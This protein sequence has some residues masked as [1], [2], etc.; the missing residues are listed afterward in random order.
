MHTY[1]RF[2]I[3]AGLSGLWYGAIELAGHLGWYSLI[4]VLLALP[5]V[6]CF[7]LWMR[8]EDERTLRKNVE[9]RLDT[10][11]EPAGCVPKICRTC[12][13]YD[14]CDVQDDDRTDFS[15]WRVY[16]AL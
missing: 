2:F 12:E 6:L 10:W 4:V 16:D 11:D 5:C 15:C 7:G 1:K 13:Y 8:L 14:R 9:G 3:A